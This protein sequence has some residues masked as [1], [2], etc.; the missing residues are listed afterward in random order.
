MAGTGYEDHVQV[1]LFNQ[2]VAVNVGKAEGGRGTPVAQQAVFNLLRLKGFFQQGVIP[3]VNHAD[4]QV[5][6]GAP[7]GMNFA[8]FFV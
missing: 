6:T 8:Q 4:G 1:V 5:V 3:Q 2:P 7:V